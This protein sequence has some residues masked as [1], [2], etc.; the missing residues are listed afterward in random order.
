MAVLD[1]FRTHKH[2]WGVP[3]KRVVDSK[4]VQTCYACSKEREV[5]VNFTLA[6]DEAERE[7]DTVALL[8]SEESAA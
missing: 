2:Y 3:H 7:R 8:Y 4:L 6:G 1:F 5:A